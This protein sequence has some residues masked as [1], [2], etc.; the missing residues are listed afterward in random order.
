M[1]QTD[2][3][4]KKVGFQNTVP[5]AVSGSFLINCQHVRTCQCYY[6]IQVYKEVTKHC[7]KKLLSQKSPIC[8]E[9]CCTY[10]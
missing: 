2:Q 1:H 6:P 5:I 7:V 4:A 9:I 8:I 3:C 10:K